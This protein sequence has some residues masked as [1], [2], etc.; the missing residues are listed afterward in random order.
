MKTIT[1]FKTTLAICILCLTLTGTTSCNKSNLN[2][3][4]SVDQRLIGKWEK[5]SFLGNNVSVIQET[6]N[7]NG[8]G[9]ERTFNLNDGATQ[10]SNERITGFTWSVL[11]EGVFHLKNDL[12]EEGDVSYFVTDN[13]SALRLTL[14][15]GDQIILGKVN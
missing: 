1:F 9:F 12:N 10:I 2:P 15:S 14:P 8:T 4:S 7:A 11:R 3:V 6:F 5:Q 13:Q